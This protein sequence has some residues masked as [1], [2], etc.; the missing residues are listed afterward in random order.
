MAL[1]PDIISCSWGFDIEDPPL[2]AAEQALA[3][4]VANAVAQGIIVIFSA[5]NGHWGFPG[6][7][8]DVI[9]AGGA[10]L[11]PLK[12]PE[13]TEY[14]SGFQSKIYPTRQV[15]DVCGLVGK[16]PAA[17]YIMLPV[18]PSDEIDAG[19]GGIPY[20]DGDDTKTNDGWAAFS[21]TS[22]AAPQLAGACALMRQAWPAMTPL[23]AKDIL[24]TTARDVTQGPLRRLDRSP[25]GGGRRGPGHRSRNRGRHQGHAAGED[26]LGRAAHGDPGSAACGERRSRHGGVG[27]GPV[28]RPG[29]RA[30]GPSQ[31]LYRAAGG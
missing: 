17:V 27:A 8:P 25:Q 18:E 16:P 2:G 1:A 6:Q 31:G 14:A 11:Q 22:A 24:K 4:A 21:G 20:P 5:G 13:A 19:Y 23:Q 9:S 30:L 10:Y 29:R 7:H 28:G 15:P 12:S 26:P 3:A